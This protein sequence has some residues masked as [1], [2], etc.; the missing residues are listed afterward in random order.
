MINHLPIIWAN[1][2]IGTRLT[3]GV[4][5]ILL[6]SL[7]V[8]L[9]GWFTLESQA[10][11]QQLANL[12]IDLVGALRAARQDEKNYM[13]RGESIHIDET[14]DAITNIRENAA[15]LKQAL[16]DDQRITVASLLLEL[17]SYQN[18]FENFVVLNNKKDKSLNEMVNQGRVLE[19]T[20]VS[21]REDQKT[22]LQ[23]LETI[24]ITSSQ[25]RQ[26]KS[27]K[28]DDANRIIKL[29]GEARQQEKN[30]LLRN[31]PRYIDETRSLV[32]QLII[33]AKSTKSRFDNKQNKLFSQQI[34]NTASDYLNE[35][36][37]VFKG[38]KESNKVEKSMVLLGREVEERSTQL[39]ED[40]KQELIK[41]EKTNKKASSQRLDKR[42]KADS[43]NRIIKLM[44]EAR[45][46]E[47]NFLLRRE[48]SY[49]EITSRLVNQV[50]KD[51]ND[52]RMRFQDTENQNL[53]SIIIKAAK[54][55][56]DKFKRVVYITE[57]NTAS[58]DKMA[59]LG[60]RLENKAIQLRGIQK[61]ELIRLEKLST[62]SSQ[63]RLDKRIKA[64][65]ANRIIKLM[66]EARQ[67]EKNYLLRKEAIYAEVTR[68]LVGKAVQ[69]AQTLRER[70]LD[71][72]NRL[73]ATKIISA[74]KTYL[75]EF[76]DVVVSEN[77]QSLQQQRMVNAA[78][79]IE[80]LATKVRLQTQFQADSARETAVNIILVTLLLALV[81]GAAMSIL[82]TNSIAKPIAKLVDVINKLANQDNVDVPLVTN[83]DEIGQIARAISNFKEVIL[84]RKAKTEAQLIQ[85]EKMASLGDLVAGVAHEINTPIGIAVTGSTHLQDEVLRLEKTFESGTLK[86]SDFKGFVENAVPT[87][88]TIQKN[89]ERASMLIKSFKQVAV[90]QS[91]QEIRTFT[92]ISY[93][94]DIL[95][96]LHPKLKNVNHTIT[97]QGDRKLQ[98]ETI[99]GAL[100]QIITNL[101]INSLN[102]GYDDDSR[103]GE[104]T[105]EVSHV[106]DI[107]LLHYADN[108]SGMSEDI[109]S[110]IYEPF[111]TTKRGRGGSG[112]GLSIIFNL[113]TQ[114]L[115]GTIEC[116][117]KPNEGSSFD[118]HFPI[119]SQKLKVASY[120]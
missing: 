91:S 65:T 34:I 107:V 37:K 43:A 96:S 118:I 59:S 47:K 6:L 112:L 50:I 102:H 20:A 93:I 67:Q 36:E 57:V 99:P 82:L 45:Q 115:N 13:L 1:F 83:K 9:V 109:I 48:A 74:A 89:L 97:V 7:I 52:L 77:K 98:V 39:R 78:R 53:A 23:R 19:N 73:L 113:V 75:Q 70:F 18:D 84:K 54:Q 51:A 24:A 106:N 5:S 62:L 119:S 114:T 12:S 38:Q 55:Y 15:F 11:S 49:A 63:Q 68:T 29:M 120:E 8:G 14:L 88:I 31:D 25:Q 116:N 86:K 108:G 2:R 105:I 71:E 44:A 85:S 17:D 58:Q 100:S 81:I 80:S 3:I 69:Q 42:E 101:V 35:L 104:I 32:N 33:Q 92:L 4:S 41:L 60:R 94:E 87:A 76:E 110:K 30:F 22:E 27:K 95:L 46:Q 40:Q 16:P 10:R 111:F 103:N 66:G 117:S 28:A 56:L 79:K 26:E 61:Q 64:D 72:Q 90:D 21:L